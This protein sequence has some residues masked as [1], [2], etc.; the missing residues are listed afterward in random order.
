MSAIDDVLRHEGFRT[1][2]YVDTQGH[3]TIGHGIN[4]DAG[5]TQDESLMIVKSRLATIEKELAKRLPFFQ[6]LTQ[7]RKDV[8][9]NMA[10][11]LGITGLMNFVRTLN[12]I[13]MGDYDAAAKGM[14][15]SLWA[16]QVK[17]RAA[18][19]ADKMRRG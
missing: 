11:N 18:E 9:I 16:R 4:L 10:Y 15:D 1:Y 12:Y 13:K 14:L 3:L 19:L 6:D 8:L 17:G 7:G 2:P 5:I